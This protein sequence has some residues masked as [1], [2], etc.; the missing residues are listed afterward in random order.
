MSYIVNI[1]IRRKK[2]F[3]VLSGAILVRCLQILSMGGGGW[4]SHCGLQPLPKCPC[5]LL[6]MSKNKVGYKY[7]HFSLFTHI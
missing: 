2:P 7:V 3:D 5:Q 4:G 1:K 6:S